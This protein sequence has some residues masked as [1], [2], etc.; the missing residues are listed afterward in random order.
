[1]ELPERFEDLPVDEQHRVRRSASEMSRFALRHCASIIIAPPPQSSAGHTNTASG[2]VVEIEQGCY[3]GTALHV[4][5]SWLSRTRN[6]ERLLFQVGSA[7][8]PPSERLV[9][10]DLDGD[11][12]FLRVDSEDVDRIGV[13]PCEALRG[14]PPP[15]PMADDS[16]VVAGYPGSERRH[17]DSESVEFGSCAALLSVTSVSDKHV[18]CQ[19]ERDRW[20]ST[21][22]TDLPPVGA[23]LAGMSGGPA[24]L[25]Q[26]VSY[27]LVGVVAE[28]LCLGEIVRIRTLAHLP[29]RF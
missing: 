17:V 29:T 9:W 25:V 15:K 12:A 4:V 20:M 5:E 18:S 3:V 7:D 2:F 8:L 13:L 1:M 14:W 19:F 26:D 10:T 16:L 23:D 28:Q 24:F 6:G 21:E 11:L 22:G 27:P